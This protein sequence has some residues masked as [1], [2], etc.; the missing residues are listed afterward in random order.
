ME[1]YVNQITATKLHEFQG[2][3]LFAKN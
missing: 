2:E 1:T 3:K